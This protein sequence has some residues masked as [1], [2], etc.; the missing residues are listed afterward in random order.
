MRAGFLR[1]LPLGVVVALVVLCEL[2]LAFYTAL[3][4]PGALAPAVQAIPDA[5]HMNN[6]RAIGK[7]LYTYYLY[8]FQ[9]AGVILLVA[10]IGA[11]VL[12]LR[13]R[14]GVRKQV[15]ARQLA[16]TREASMTVV[17]VESGKGI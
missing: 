14:T 13:R 17:K 6:T 3:T 7:V 2:A 11:I 15:I 9:L 1:Y 12:T 16:R 8:P 5:A 4:R 10:M